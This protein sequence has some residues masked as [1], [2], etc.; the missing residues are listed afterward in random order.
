ME[1]RITN[2][3]RLIDERGLRHGF[4]AAKVGVSKASLSRWCNG[5]RRIPAARVDALAAAIGVSP[6]E[7]VGER[8]GVA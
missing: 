4:V 5:A 8:V 1:T 6:E 2:L 3:A 7:I